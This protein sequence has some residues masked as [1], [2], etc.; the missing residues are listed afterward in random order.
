MASYKIIFNPVSKDGLI[1]KYRDRVESLLQQENIDY[2]LT[3]TQGPRHAIDLAMQAKEEGFHYV[4]AF[5]GD[6]TSNEVLNGAVK[7]G[8]PVGF[9]PYGSG[10]DLAGGLGY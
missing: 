3:A 6:G 2:E 7:V 1:K 9:I 5:G 4:V 8:L 10:N